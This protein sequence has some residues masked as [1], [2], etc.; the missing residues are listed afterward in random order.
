MPTINLTLPVAGTEIVAG[1]HATNYTNLQTLLNGA[2]DNSNVSTTADLDANARVGVRKNSAGSTFERRRVN[3]IEGAG[4]S[5]TV[6]DDAANE[7]VDVTVAVAGG[8][9]LIEDKLLAST[10][11][12]LDFTAIPA[13][14]KHL[15]LEISARSDVA[16]TFTNTYARVNNDSGANYDFEYVENF[17]ATRSS[18]ES[19]GV[20][21]GV[22]V[23]ATVGTTGTANRFGSG[24]THILN[25]ASTDMH[26]IFRVVGGVAYSSAANGIR[27]LD[28]YGVWRNTA[29]ID[30]LTVYPQQPASGGNFAAGTR[31]T[32]Y[33]VL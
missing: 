12:T 19:F 28:A 30:R 3:L 29:A 1:L 20:V 4:V 17:A 13:T 10:A 16:T 32:L 23:G 25:Y 24:T 7:E 27:T 8:M 5:L 14:Y 11:A 26:K 22:I 33:G 21:F 15:V 18:S 9:F 6:A 2:L 31:A